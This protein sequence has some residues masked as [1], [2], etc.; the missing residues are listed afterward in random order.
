MNETIF[1]LVTKPINQNIAVIRIS[2]PDSF[3][4]ASKLLLTKHNFA[5]NQVVY[6]R[7]YD[8]NKE[9][10][11]EGLLLSF[12][13][14][15]SFTGENVVEIQTHGSMFVVEKL[16]SVL[17]KDTTA[18][19]A[20]PGEFTKQA[21]LNK[22]LDLTK[23]TAI[24]SLINSENKSLAEKS[25]FNLEGKQTKFI[26][27]V[28]K[29]LENLIARIQVAID[30]PENTDMEE[31]SYDQIKQMVQQNLKMVDK[32]IEDSKTLQKINKGITIAIV[33]EPNAGKSTLLN[34][35]VGEDRVIVS[36]I[37]GTTRDVID[38]QMRIN[39]VVVTFKD[40]AGLRNQTDD[41]LERIGIKK[42]YS[43]IDEADL[44][45]WL[46]DIN[47][48][49]T[50]LPNY[51]EDKTDKLI[52]VISKSDLKND[53][54]VLPKDFIDISAKNKKIFNLVTEIENFIKVSLPI[55]ESFKNNYLTDKLQIDF[56]EQIRTNLNSSL[57][58]LEDEYSQD[59]ILF[60]LENSL[61]ILYKMLGKKVDPDY[62]NNLFGGFCLGK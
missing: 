37:K 4:A 1:A 30:Y 61:E 39:D 3:V 44:I 7:F 13:A 54:F 24:N 26:N 62:I 27:E 52:K 53:N 47:N 12:E 20:Y 34:E 49:S 60:E 42:A 59:F 51:L 11:D 15:N 28:I 58:F 25:I 35:I 10:I 48:F 56:F 17:Q 40:T 31:Y 5:P 50:T 23:A 36:D 57:N 9:F 2:G 16:L 43:I 29:N 41:I 18:R 45:L 14:P 32:I 19:M 6:Q 21:F 8:S 22:K 46:Q 55:N 33:G 38:V